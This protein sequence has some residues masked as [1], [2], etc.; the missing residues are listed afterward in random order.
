MSTPPAAAQIK[1]YVD[2]LLEILERIATALE[3]QRVAA[4]YAAQNAAAPLSP[5]VAAT[6]PVPPEPA[7][8]APSPAQEAISYDQVRQ[9]VLKYQDVKGI[10]AAQDVLKAFGARYIMDLKARP[11]AYADVLKALK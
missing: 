4:I 5:P 1:V 7:P 6:S 10:K 11:E 9:A 3:Q 8:D 2:R